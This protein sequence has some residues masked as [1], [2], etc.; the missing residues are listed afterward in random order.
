M[1]TDELFGEELAGAGRSPRVEWLEAAKA[2]GLGALVYLDRDLGR[3]KVPGSVL[4]FFDTEAEAMD[5]LCETTARFPTFD[6]WRWDRE[7]SGM[8]GGDL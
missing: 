4:L 3:W 2:A 6:R 7:K 1:E 8:E 5:F